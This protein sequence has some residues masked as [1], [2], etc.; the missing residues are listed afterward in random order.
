MAYFAGFSRRFVVVIRRVVVGRSDRARIFVTGYGGAV[1]G[2]FFR[3]VGGVFGVQAAQGIRR[4][5]AGKHCS[6]YYH[7]VR[8]PAAFGYQVEVS[9]VDIQGAADGGG[10]AVKPKKPA[11]KYG[12]GKHGV[13][14]SGWAGWTEQNKPKWVQ[15]HLPNVRSPQDVDKIWR[16]ARGLF[17]ARLT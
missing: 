9:A 16:R 5:K 8:H 2:S 10:A 3:A 12:K 4:I 15:L 11:K 13:P 17:I 14:H 1:P 7:A 6:A